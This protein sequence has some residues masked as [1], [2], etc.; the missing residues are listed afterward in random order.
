MEG[1][2]MDVKLLGFLTLWL[3]IVFFLFLICPLDPEDGL[4]STKTLKKININ[5]FKHA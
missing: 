2:L 4:I 1:Q 5:H 3:N